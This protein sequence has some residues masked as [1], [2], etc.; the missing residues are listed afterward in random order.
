MAYDG[1][2]QEL[3]NIYLSGTR[4]FHAIMY[5]LWQPPQLSGT[6]TASIPVPVGYQP[7]QFEGTVAQK[8]PIGGGKWDKAVTT[9]AGAVG[10]F[11]PSLDTD[12]AIYGYPTWGGVSGIG[13]CDAVNQT[14]EIE[15]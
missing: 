10:G 6:G 3:P 2:G 11:T 5:L 7:W 1:P 15:E 13:S 14:Q 4:D 9:A 12:N 8:A